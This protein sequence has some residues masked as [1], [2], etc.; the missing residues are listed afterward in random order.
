MFSHHVKRS[1][2]RRG[3]H[4]CYVTPNGIQSALTDNAMITQA[5]ETLPSSVNPKGDYVVYS[6][7]EIAYSRLKDC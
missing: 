7:K 6:R 5:T 4:A 3:F 2:A 1:I